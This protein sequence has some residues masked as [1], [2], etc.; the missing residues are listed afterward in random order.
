M[1]RHSPD[2]TAWSGVRFWPSLWYAKD[3]ILLAVFLPLGLSAQIDPCGLTWHKINSPNSPGQLIGQAATYDARRQVAVL[4]GGNN[5][6]TGVLFTGDTWEWNGVEWSKS[7]PGPPPR[8]NAAMAYDTDRGVCVLFG[9]GT[10]IFPSQTPFNDTWER[11]GTEWIRRQGNDPSAADRPPPL[12]GP[13]MVYD[14]FRKRIVLLGASEHING[15]FKPS[16][17]T[18]EWDGKVWTVHDR[19]TSPSPAPSPRTDAA[20]AYDS[21][22]QV[23]VLFG[24]YRYAGIGLLDDTWTWD[25]VAWKQVASGGTPSREEHAMAFDEGRKVVV[26]F[27]G[28]SLRGGQIDVLVDTSEWDGTSWKP[29]PFASYNLNTARRL[30]KMWYD[31][32]D[33][34]V[35]M[36]GGMI[37]TG[38]GDTLKHTILDDLWEARWPGRWVDFSYAGAPSKPESGEFDEPFNLLTEAVNAAPPGC[39]INLKP[40]FSGEKIKVIK[41]LKLRAYSGAATI[42]GGFIPN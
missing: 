38:N 23:T 22:R 19:L 30:H 15:E 5:P 7:N 3:W 13:M 17:R 11:N 18:W 9:G 34:K 27:S 29:L 1:K 16:E 32:H 6:V 10:N 21:A 8:K 2:Q 35:V 4:F 37:T 39:T 26:L 42:G 20:M 31:R 14:S 41:P 33:Q 24:G 36:F 25:G 12:E 40:G 28:R